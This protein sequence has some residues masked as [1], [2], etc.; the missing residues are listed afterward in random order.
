MVFRSIGRETYLALFVTIPGI[1]ALWETRDLNAMSALFPQ[2]VGGILI[3]LGLFQLI[4]SL[5]RPNSGKR[6]STV[7]WRVLLMIASMATYTVLIGVIGFLPA[8]LVF[9]G[10]AVW[11]LQGREVGS[12]RRISRAV[13]FSI[14]VSVVCFLL[15]RYVFMVPFPTGILGD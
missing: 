13:L 10:W 8:T 6:T 1:I 15:F 9:T 14:A 2:V 4:C 3:G 5:L 7:R 12:F 11:V